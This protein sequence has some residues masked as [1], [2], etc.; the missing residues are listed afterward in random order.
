[1]QLIVTFASIF[2]AAYSTY[3]LSNKLGL[4]V[5]SQAA[6]W[7]L[8]GECHLLRNEERNSCSYHSTAFS[9]YV[10]L[11]APFRNFEPRT[12]LLAIF[13]AFAPCFII[14]SICAE[15]FFYLTYCATL[16]Q[17]VEVEAAVRS[18]SGETENLRNWRIIYR[19]RSDDIRIALFFLFF[20]QIAFYGTGK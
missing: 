5:L 19:P 18:C 13:L 9:V 11:H 7:I 20:V 2:V 15:G 8:L 3:R 16:L 1:M 6:G 12:K 10:P 14:L 4:P 17:W